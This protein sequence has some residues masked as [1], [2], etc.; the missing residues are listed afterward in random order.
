M[1][2]R[3]CGMESRTPQTCEWCKKPLA[4]GPAG[5][6]P[7][8]QTAQPLG[9]PPPLAQPL[10]APALT[11]V[12]QQMPPSAG[13]LPTPPAPEPTRVLRTTLTGEVIEVAPPTA[14]PQYAAP[15]GPMPP[16][17]APSYPA[18]HAVVS[19]ARATPGQ[20]RDRADVQAAPREISI[21]ER[22]ELFLAIALPLLLGSVILVH[23]MPGL[24]LWVLIGDLFL[25][26]LILGSTGAVPSYDDAV[27]DVTLMLGIMFVV[28]VMLAFPI[29]GPYGLVFAS[30]LRP[31]IALAIY[32]V[33]GLVR[34]EWNMAIVGLFVLNIVIDG[35]LTYA[36]LTS[37]AKDVG[38]LLT[39]GLVNWLKYFGTFLGM[40][41]WII[42]SVFRPMEAQ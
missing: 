42:S 6:Q 35:S 36:M 40:L 26:S 31:A 1:R 38:S 14:P 37:P 29:L 25:L 30:L 4:A 2:C 22:F 8:A 20:M 18:T 33:V 9:G 21:G 3:Y 23:A 27:A 7:V 34:Q 16:G 13:P 17:A 19:G 24:F 39:L 12:T 15:P 11:D 28:R 5:A 10:N 41:G 32:G